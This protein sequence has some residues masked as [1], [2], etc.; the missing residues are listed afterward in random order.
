MVIF[1][2]Q[3]DRYPLYCECSGDSHETTCR[4]RRSVEA[5]Q[6]IQN[7]ISEKDLVDAAN[8]VY[9]EGYRGEDKQA[10][11][12]GF[13]HPDIVDFEGRLLAGAHQD[14]VEQV[15]ES[16]DGTVEVL[17]RC[18]VREYEARRQQG[19]W[20]EANALLVSI[21]IRSLNAIREK[22][23]TSADPWIVD[24]LYSSTKGLEL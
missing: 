4:V 14:W 18:L 3:V 19:L 24:S 16:T 12:E 20:I 2:K 21:R 15:I 9:A 5:L 1:T 10:F 17:P 8:H 13:N 23:D 6:G 22:L 7:P 11:D